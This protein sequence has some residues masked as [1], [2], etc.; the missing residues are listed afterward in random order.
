L[1][2]AFNPVHYGHLRA[3]EEAKQCLGLDRVIFVPAG[4][5]PF[6][7]K[8]QSLASA[9]DRLEMTRL[10]VSGSP[11]FEVS[12]IECRK[13]GPS[14]TVETLR[15]LKSVYPSDDFFFILGMDAFLEMHLWREPERLLELASFIVVP[16]PGHSFLEVIQSAFVDAGKK[17][18]EQLQGF[19]NRGQVCSAGIGLKN[20]GTL[21]LLR[22]P[23]MEISS[24]R[25]RALI[26]K[27]LEARYLLPESV[28]SYIITKGLYR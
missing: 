6:R 11:G 18:S 21:T 8:E 20:G 16:R 7:D 9:A 13:P 5:P 25:I 10:A 27:G 15:E 17:P 12:D 26:S 14:Y 4:T 28:L 22:M 3:A 19:L 2:G 1:G 24:S 23:V